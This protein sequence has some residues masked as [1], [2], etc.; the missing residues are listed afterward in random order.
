MGLQMASPAYRK[1]SRVPRFR[2]KTP[3]DSPESLDA[4]VARSLEDMPKALKMRHAM[5]DEGD[6]SEPEWLRKRPAVANVRTANPVTFEALLEDWCRERQS[7]P[8]SVR[9]YTSRIGTFTKFLGH[10]DASR[11]TADDVQRWKNHLRVCIGVL[12]PSQ[13]DS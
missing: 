9:A 2:L 3:A 13:S 10:Q 4:L 11:V 7:K 12:D 6:Y 8:T 1:G 5:A